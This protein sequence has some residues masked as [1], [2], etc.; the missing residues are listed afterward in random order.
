MTKTG[1]AAPPRRIAAG[2]IVAVFCE[3][4]GAWTAAQITDVDT[5]SATAGV[6][7]LDWFGPEPERVADLGDVQPLRLSHHSWAGQIS[8]CNYDW[9][10][11]RGFKVI[12]SLPLFHEQRSNSYGGGWGVGQ[13]LFL[14]RRW[15]EGLRDTW[16]DPH[17]ME[18][19]GA[20]L[21]MLLEKTAEPD[22][23]LRRLTVREIEA[24]D[25]ARLVARFPRL[26]SLSLSGALGT[27]SGAGRL[28]E[29]SSLK[30]LSIR[31]LFGMGASDCLLPSHAVALESL[32]LDSVPAEYAKAMGSAWR[33]EVAM[34]TYLDIRKPR[35]PEW[36]AENRDN[37]F[38]EWDGDGHVPRG[39]YKKTLEYYKQTRD[40]VVAVLTGAPSGPSNTEQASQL[41]EIGERY[42][43]A[44]NALDVRYEFIETIERE[45][46]FEVLDGI[47]AAVEAELGTELPWA[48]E[49]LAE[50]ADSVRDW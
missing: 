50:G 30:R 28:N 9:V 46:L 34:G 23:D 43:E 12:G 1:E 13:Q 15:D 48:R 37:P 20:D 47:V 38:R 29:L 44:F 22:T 25:G 39:A 24:L 4:L 42:G 19:S 40:A 3:Q 21:N 6:L 8:H 31:N 2:D 11:P 35:K 7:D 16:S 26:T 10:L 17:A 33:P 18:C 27:F 45:H 49:S 41:Y 14:Q 32:E 36:V 5:G